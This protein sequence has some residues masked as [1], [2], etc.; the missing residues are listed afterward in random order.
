MTFE[1][2]LV[3]SVGRALLVVLYRLTQ[4]ERVA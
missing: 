2:I 1:A 3:E 4:A